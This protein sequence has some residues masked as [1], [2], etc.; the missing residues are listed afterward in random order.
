MRL[1]SMGYMRFN[2]DLFSDFNRFEL[3]Q[4]VNLGE[5]LQHLWAIKTYK[6]YGMSPTQ[7]AMEMIT[8]G[9]PSA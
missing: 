5:I 1:D 3:P 7:Q 6:L 8:D 9:R 2:Y 4:W